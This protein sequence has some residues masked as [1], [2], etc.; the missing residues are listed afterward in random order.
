MDLDE[1]FAF[2]KRGDW[3]RFEFDLL[4]TSLFVNLSVVRTKRTK[5]EGE[6]RKI[7]LRARRMSR[8][9]PLAG[10]GL[11]RRAFI[12]V[13]MDEE[14]MARREKRVSGVWGS[15]KRRRRIRRLIDGR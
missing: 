12:V 2:R 7:S 13:G 6:E 10:L 5:R 4:R 1:D 14:D 11:T 15:E 9:V 8:S 3:D